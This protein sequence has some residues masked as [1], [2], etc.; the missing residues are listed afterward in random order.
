MGIIPAGRIIGIKGIIFVGRIVRVPV[1][2]VRGVWGLRL[3]RTGD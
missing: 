3:N 2:G 1:I